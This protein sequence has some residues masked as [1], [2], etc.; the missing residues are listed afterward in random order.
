MGLGVA[1]VASLLTTHSDG[2]PSGY[3]IAQCANFLGTLEVLPYCCAIVVLSFFIFLSRLPEC[4]ASQ[5][6]FSVPIPS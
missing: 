2:A 1:D 5:Q 6:S 3:V 4:P